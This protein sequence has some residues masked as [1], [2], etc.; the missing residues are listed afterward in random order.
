[1][2]KLT[3]ESYMHAAA[4]HVLATWLRDLSKPMGESMATHEFPFRPNRGA[5]WYGVYEEFPL[6]HGWNS[7]GNVMIHDEHELD[8]PDGSPLSYAEMMAR[9]IVPTV[10]LDVA[11][12]SKGNIPRAFEIVH[13]HYTELEKILYLERC[14]ILVVEVSAEWILRQTKAISAVDEIPS[15]RSFGGGG[16]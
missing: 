5:P 7:C 9:G 1:M 15:L 10:I 13:K 6:V 8:R 2:L 4:R 16:W 3:D 11:I 14:E 12:A